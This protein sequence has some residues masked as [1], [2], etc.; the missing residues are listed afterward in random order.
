MKLVRS[1]CA[2]FLYQSQLVNYLTEISHALYLYKKLLQVLHAFKLISKFVL[3]LNKTCT[4]SFGF[5]VGNC[6]KAV[7][8][9]PIN[10][11]NPDDKTR[12]EIVKFRITHNFSMNFFHLTITFSQHPVAA[13]FPNK[14]FS[15]EY[16]ANE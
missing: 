9:F 15:Y 16:T 4:S 2:S 12:A 3:T 14:K 1:C 7:F 11:K 6:L 10:L 13:N 5:T 8:P